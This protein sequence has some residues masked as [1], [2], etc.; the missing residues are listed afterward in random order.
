MRS[1]YAKCTVKLQ[2]Y[3]DFTSCT[4]VRSCSHD[5][6]FHSQIMS[7][8]WLVSLYSPHMKP[9]KGRLCSVTVLQTQVQHHAQLQAR[10]YYH[11]GS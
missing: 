11:H 7:K 6:L 2:M 3:E 4:A 5:I 10:I 9:S 8:T 1:Q